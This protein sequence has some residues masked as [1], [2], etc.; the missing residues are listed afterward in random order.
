MGN[1]EFCTECGESDFHYGVSCNPEKR[2]KYQH[3]QLMTKG[4]YLR[5]VQTREAQ[6]R[7]AGIPFRTERVFWES[8][9]PVRIIVQL[10]DY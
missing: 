3:E 7:A 5:A 2:Q 9:T 10:D 1:H 4:R 6:L 8:E